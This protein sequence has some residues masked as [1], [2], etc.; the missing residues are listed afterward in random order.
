MRRASRGRLEEPVSMRLEEGYAVDALVGVVVGCAADWG[1]DGG[2]GWL[3]GE[4]VCAALAVA[5]GVLMPFVSGAGDAMVV[6][7]FA[8]P[9]WLEWWVSE[10]AGEARRCGRV[11]GLAQLRRLRRAEMWGESAL[12]RRQ[13]HASF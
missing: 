9:V 13:V 10:V 2:C 7:G 5:G 8:A 1:C 4:F 3:G 12:R 6:C 11:G